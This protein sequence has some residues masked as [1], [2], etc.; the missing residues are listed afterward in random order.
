MTPAVPASGPAPVAAP[1]PAAERAPTTAPAPRAEF[2]QAVRLILMA[3]QGSAGVGDD[4]RAADEPVRFHA[5]D[6]MRHPDAELTALVRTAPDAPVD[7]TVAFMGLT[8]PSGV[9][10]DHYSDLMVERRRARDEAFGQFLDM[11][12]HRAIS[13]FYR[14][15]A[16]YRLPVRFGAVDA[17]GRADDPFTQAL[18]ALS[19]I[20][21]L[22]DDAHMLAMAGPLNRRVRSAGALRRMLETLYDLP[23]SIIELRPRWIRIAP[24]E[25]TRLP[26][27][28]IPNGH[29]A[30]LARDAVIGAGAYDLAGRFRI[31]IGPLDL[32]TFRAFFQ[33]D[34]IRHTL[35]R[36]IRMAVGGTIDFD[37]Q[38]VL[39]GDAVPRL[40]LGDP[41]AP[42][43][44]GQN[45]WLTS[46]PS[47]ADREDAILPGTLPA[48]AAA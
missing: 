38:L 29:Y 15:W 40:R 37:L 22:G 5:A 42:A 28:D 2:F 11:F 9:M 43:H 17:A 47:V 6:G 26:A 20:T 16:K 48:A 13:L 31:R 3:A 24:D 21:R 25:C 10:P 27:A 7:M 30:A 4:S 44:L 14:A 41:D 46:G 45:S 8:G 18:A 35:T 32:P 1:A 34:G 19:G 36:S 33:P 39:R 23:V 12:N